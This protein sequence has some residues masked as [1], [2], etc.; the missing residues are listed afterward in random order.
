M[1]FLKDYFD[2]LISFFR[3]VLWTICAPED[4][5]LLVEIVW[6]ISQCELLFITSLLI[7]RCLIINYNINKIFSFYIFKMFSFIYVFD[8]FF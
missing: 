1:M 4:V 3:V 5:L 7:Q 6:S 8:S 2:V